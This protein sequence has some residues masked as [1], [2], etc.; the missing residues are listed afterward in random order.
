LTSSSEAKII[1][2]ALSLALS[3]NLSVAAYDFDPAELERVYQSKNFKKV[4]ELAS[5]RLVLDPYDVRARYFL[6]GAL[7]HLGRP[8][9]AMV[10][11]QACVKTAG[12]TDLAQQSRKAI[13]VIEQGLKNGTIKSATSKD[14]ISKSAIGN[15]PVKKSPG[16]IK[17]EEDIEQRRTVLKKELEDAIAVKRLSQSAELERIGFD[18]QMAIEQAQFTS[19]QNFDLRERLTR[20]A[21]AEAL[22]RREKVYKNFA[23]Q[24][25]RLHEAYEKLFKDLD[26]RK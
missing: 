5:A 26:K 17:H 8:S 20:A 2:M 23:D 24:E 19:G 12:Q 9:Q 13:I 21:T 6:A 4:E 10:Q 11:Y 14:A 1:G 22:E 7:L 16:Q 18:E 3:G 15:K 25:V